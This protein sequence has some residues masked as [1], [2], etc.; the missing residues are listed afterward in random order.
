MNSKSLTSI[1]CVQ[2]EFVGLRTA[3]EIREIRRKKE[4]QEGKEEAA[5]EEEKK[6]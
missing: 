4:E 3:E 1:S 2:L 5:K 6:R